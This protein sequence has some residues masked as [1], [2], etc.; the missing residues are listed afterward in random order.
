MIDILPFAS[1]E[2]INRH[3]KFRNLVCVDG[4]NK[5]NKSQHPSDLIKNVL[6]IFFRDETGETSKVKALMLDA[7]QYFMNIRMRFRQHALHPIIP[8]ITVQ[9]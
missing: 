3:E 7:R 8:S 2:M 6:Q 9:V 5:I 4:A 1:N